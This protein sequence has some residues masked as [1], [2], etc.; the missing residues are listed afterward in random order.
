MR[1]ALFAVHASK[2]ASL[3]L[4]YAFFPEDGCLSNEFSS[5]RPSL[6]GQRRALRRG[7]RWPRAVGNEL[8]NLL[9]A[10]ARRGCVPLLALCAR[11]D[12]GLLEPLLARAPLLSLVLP[13]SSSC[14]DLAIFGHL[15]WP[16]R[17]MTFGSTEVMPPW[18]DKRHSRFRA[19]RDRLLEIRS[20][21]RTDHPQRSGIQCSFVRC[22]HPG[23][24][25]RFGRLSAVS[26][27]VDQET[28]AHRAPGQ[29]QVRLFGK[30]WTSL[31]C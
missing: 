17:W 13:K 4:S 18:V 9:Q 3:L 21:S 12:A 29:A 10:R 24:L 30:R 2:A 23:A 8:L 20:T 26:A 1:L 14:H 11:F 22:A 28:G 31:C 16:G 6:A 5:S 25:S 19:S 15:I 27:R 7:W